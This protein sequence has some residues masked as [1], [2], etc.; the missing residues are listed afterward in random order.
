MM[1]KTL[2]SPSKAIEFFIENKNSETSLQDMDTFIKNLDGVKSAEVNLSTG[3]TKI[4]LNED[5]VFDQKLIEIQRMIF[6]K[7]YEVKAKNTNA[8]QAYLFF[9]TMVLGF[10]VVAV[11]MTL[12]YYYGSSLPSLV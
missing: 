10:L 5:S 3:Q 7:G 8:I 2:N 1:P 11:V 12:F 9:G 6:Q 4:T